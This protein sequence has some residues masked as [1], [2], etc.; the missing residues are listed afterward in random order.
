MVL[1][2]KYNVYFGFDFIDLQTFCYSDESKLKKEDPQEIK[3][4][5][6]REQKWLKMIN[7]WNNVSKDKLKRRVYKGIPNSLRGKVWAKL[8]RVDQ[9]TND[10]KDKYKVIIFFSKTFISCFL[11]Y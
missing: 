11:N 1:C 9:L 7:N 8:L 2:G 5:R 4:E 6:I 10:Q 3:I